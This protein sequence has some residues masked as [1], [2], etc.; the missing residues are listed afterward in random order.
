MMKNLVRLSFTVFSI[1]ILIASCKQS[2]VS[3]NDHIK[4]LLNKECVACH[5]GIKKAGGLSLL[6]RDAAIA[7]NE[8]SGRAAIVP[9]SAKNSEIYKRVISN[10]PEYMMPRSKEH[11]LEEDEAK[12]IKQWIDDGAKWGTHWAYT[13]VV[14]RDIPKTSNEWA[15]TDIDKFILI[16][17]EEKNLLPN[18]IAAKEDLWRRA[19]FDITGLPVFDRV[20]NEDYEDM[21]DELLSSTA[22]GEHWASMWLDLARYADSH[23]YEKDTHRNIWRY[24]DWV[25]NAFNADMPFDQFTI[26][27]LAGDLID[28]N[29]QDKLIATS[30]H[31]NSMTN[32]EGG[33]DDEEFRVA[34]VI[35]RLNTTFEIWQSTPIGCAQCHDHPYDPISQVE[36]Y[37]SLSFFNNTVDADLHGD[38]PMLELYESDTEEK[39]DSLIN[40]ISKITDNHI[41]IDQLPSKKISEALYPT[42]LP[43]DCD[44][45]E[46]ALLFPDGVICNWTMNVSDMEGRQFYFIYENIDFNGLDSI[47]F[48]YA[49]PGEISFLEG[50]L[51][52]K[53]GRLLFNT[54]FEKTR[55]N[56][57]HEWSG[58]H[59]W[60]TKTVAIEKD[61]S[62][63]HD[64]L[65]EIQN[66][67]MIVPDGILLFKQIDLVY[68]DVIVSDEL[69]SVKKELVKLRSIAEKTPI[70]V[71]KSEKLR[72]TNQL[73]VRGNHRI[74]ADTV[75]E[76][77]PDVLQFKAHDITDRLELAHW[78]VDKEN[79]LTARVMVN[80][81]WERIFGIGIVETL[82]DFGSM[83]EAPTNQALLDHLAYQFMHK[84]N[85]SFK[86]MIKEIMMSNTYRQSSIVDDDKI[87]VDPYN[88]FLGRGP[89]SRL[90]AEQIRDQALYIS[91]LLYDT[92]GGKSV[93][94]PQPN[95][96]WQ[97]VYNNQK[98]K[99]SEGKQKY[100]RGLY[101]YWKRSSPYPSMEAFDSPSR[102]F[103]KSRRIKTNTPTQALVTLNDPVYLEAANA[104][105]ELMKAHSDEPA[106][107]IKYAYK[108]GLGKD[109]SRIIE[110]TLS[111][112]YSRAEEELS[113]ATEEN[114]SL[115]SP[116]AVVAHAI[117][118]LDG[119]LNKT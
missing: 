102:E 38:Y 99:E 88:K 71:Q 22:Y 94:P 33:S 4:P 69:N 92:I 82:E 107:Q 47:K 65:F 109:P 16:K 10:D 35:D 24:R 110:S 66:P 17:L 39:I 106:E 8:K 67:Q 48:S 19:S 60:K 56:S 116:A 64:L 103:C 46:N 6:Y 25:I 9:G 55:S 84:H 40:F 32:M 75:N 30:F 78:L 62:G 59:D 108:K 91:Q 26:E 73:F 85:W 52:S 93:M 14:L 15:A 12:L 11:K 89:R 117:F 96:V 54:G 18:E 74:R 112:L 43:R 80:R 119:F 1:L 27:Q 42:L 21:I 104:L 68:E 50:R 28:P 58:S 29:D 36:F 76:R 20:E 86:S 81:I 83:G 49:T 90:S 44:D 77:I 13:P 72:R 34:A 53:E 23:G 115:V 114:T 61:I 105:G 41:E 70:M 95:D 98:W 37:E 101:T 97:T 79:P 113:I 7:R 31:R 45:F 51:D 118:N 2:E 111:E 63:K 3:F 100:R 5:G 57:G 87:R